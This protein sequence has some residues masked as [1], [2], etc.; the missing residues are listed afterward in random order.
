MRP[1]FWIP[2]RAVIP[3]RELKTDAALSLGIGGT[4]IGWSRPQELLGSSHYMPFE[5]V[6]PLRTEALIVAQLF[7]IDC[8]EG[9][10]L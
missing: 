2:L 3:S 1:G 10:I 5:M 8:P 6:P 4:H 9:E 7:P